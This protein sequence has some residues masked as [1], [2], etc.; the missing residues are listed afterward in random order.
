MK[1]VNERSRLIVIEGGDGTG[2][3]T[4]T[5]KLCVALA[6]GGREI[7]HVREPG[8]TELG[9]KVRAMLLDLPAAGEAEVSP[10]AETFLYMAARAQL[11]SEVLEPARDAGRLVLLERFYYSTYAYQ[12]AGLGMDRELIL[13]MGE[14]AVGHVRPDVVLLFD[15]DPADSF[16]RLGAGRD[17]VESRDIDYHRRV[18]DGFLELA[19]LNGDIFRVIDA[20]GTPEEVHER[21]LE[22]LQDVL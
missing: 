9:E 12:G 6:A 15:M 3:T 17:R 10:Y 4:Q 16:R 5:E 7:L 14:T 8:S 13:R 21:V 22:A 20:A 2:K 1:S 11:F 19:E 18:R